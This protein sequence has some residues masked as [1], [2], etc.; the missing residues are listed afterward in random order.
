MANNLY[1]TGKAA[2]N[3]SRTVLTSLL[4]D[5]PENKLCYQAVPRSN[6]ALWIMGHIA[7]TDESFLAD[8]AKRP[9]DRFNA[10][11]EMF[12][13]GSTPKANPT[14]YPRLSEIR[15]CLTRSRGNLIEWLGSLSE[16]QLLAPLSG[17][18]QSFAPT[19]AAMM[20]SI[21]CHEAMHAG[22]L[23][24]IRKSLGFKPKFG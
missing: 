5:I 2:L 4:E 24:I 23:T 20:S 14:D 8:I 21:A 13:T 1:E 18:M 3:F 17:E 11:K 9:A 7:I 6:H 22:Q 16:Q 19:L 15:D 10:W 12:F